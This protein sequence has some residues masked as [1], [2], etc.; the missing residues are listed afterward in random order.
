VGYNLGPPQRLLEIDKELWR[1]RCR[2]DLVSFAVEVLAPRSERPARHHRRLCAELEAI[3]R[4]DIDRLMVLAPPGSAKTTYVSQIFVA[5]LL[6]RKNTKVIAV[7]HTVELAESNSRA[8]QRLIRDDQDVLGITLLNDSVSHW[9]TSNGCE[10]RAIG[11]GTAVRGARADYIV[12]DDPIRSRADGESETARATLWE[13]Y[14]SDLMSRLTPSGAVI[15]IATPFH[16]N[17]LMCRLLR[18]QT[19]AWR[20]LRMPAIAEADDQLGRME[21]EPLW[22]DD[23]RYGYGRKLLEL[24]DIAEK[25]GRARDW[26][27]QYQGRPRPPEGSLFKILRIPIIQ[28]APS[29]MARVR[30]WDLASSAG[31]GD[32]TVGILLGQY[33]DGYDSRYIVLD[34]R[35]IRGAPEEVRQLVRDTAKMDGYGTK[36]WI[37]RDPAQAGAD[38]ADSYIR[39]LTG[40]PIDSERMSGDKVWRADAVSAQCN[41]GRVGLLYAGWNNTLLDE[42]ASFPSGQFDDQADALSLAFSKLAG[43]DTL[44]EWLRL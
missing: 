43:N 19:D 32:W 23:D 38:Q 8:V 18:E 25:E 24:R 17:D 29:I 10:Y 27:A 35:R 12:I 20:V 37:P 9:Y 44:A 14:H 34:V 11:A 7:S 4:K 1:R 16:E 42:L 3:T 41:I 5:W 33:Y 26:F 13:F 21:G 31:K 39:M 36:I 22:A 6:T 15:L 2:E 30:A 40:Y 28:T